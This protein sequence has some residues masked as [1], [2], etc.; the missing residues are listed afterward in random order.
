MLHFLVALSAFASPIGC[1]LYVRSMLRGKAKPNRVTWFLWALAPLIAFSASVSQ[2]AT[3][4]TLS[5]FMSGFSPLLVFGASF[6]VKNAYWK[7]TP[8][9]YFCGFLSLFALALW[10]ATQDAFYAVL[11]AVLADF[12]A[13]VPTFIKAYWHPESEADSSFI[14]GLISSS[15]GLL[16]VQEWH[17]VEYGFP[18]YLAVACLAFIV[19]IRF[20]GHKLKI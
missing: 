9:D 16:A 19:L 12:L 3:W 1:I 4:S 6:F 15:F 20:R 10:A 13:G 8:L 11:F 7:V 17:F 5:I 18:L 2:G 14:G